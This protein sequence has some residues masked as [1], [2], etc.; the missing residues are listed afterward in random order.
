MAG[1][2]SC[3]SNDVKHRAYGCL[4]RSRTQTHIGVQGEEYLGRLF[5]A[6]AIVWQD[7]DAEC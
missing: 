3:V 7:A 5:V 6:A 4:G 2:I 1:L